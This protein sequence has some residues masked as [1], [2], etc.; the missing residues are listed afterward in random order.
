MK[1]RD[2]LFH[3]G[4]FSN[5]QLLPNNLSKSAY[6][7]ST[8][9]FWKRKEN[10]RKNACPSIQFLWLTCIEY[11]HNS[12]QNNADFSQNNQLYLWLGTWDMIDSTVE[13]QTL[14]ANTIINHSLR[15]PQGM[16]AAPSHLDCGEWSN[17][18][19]L[20]TFHSGA[21]HWNQQFNTSSSFCF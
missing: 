13:R 21:Q 18:L 6:S 14:T 4:I 10:I 7:K 9:A 1:V 17:A 20:Y 11:I 16:S 2:F 3:S 19:A 5:V 8:N 15:W 12:M